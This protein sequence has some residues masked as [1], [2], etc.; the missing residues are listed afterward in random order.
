M[1]ARAGTA[2]ALSLA[3]RAAPSASAAARTGHRAWAARSRLTS[4]ATS[5]GGM[6]RRPEPT[7][8]RPAGQQATLTKTQPASPC[9]T[10][11]RT[12]AV[13]G[14]LF[15]EGSAATP[16]RTSVGS[17]T[18][19]AAGAAEAAS[20][21]APADR[22]PVCHQAHGPGRQESSRRAHPRLVRT[23]AARSAFTQPWPPGSASSPPTPSTA[24]PSR[25][26]ATTTPPTSNR[27]QLPG[28]GKVERPPTRSPASSSSSPPGALT[29]STPSTRCGRRLAAFLSV[30]DRCSQGGRDCPPRRGSSFFR[31]ASL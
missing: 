27:Q 11:G 25:S 16:D 17:A 29:A 10:T 12:G 20:A 1:A 22:H 9:G 6:P 26:S 15:P 13:A 7:T 21:A 8:S 18:A 14:D 5:P 4:P 19:S 30:P 31:T 24:T 28:G 2:S 23:R 3:R